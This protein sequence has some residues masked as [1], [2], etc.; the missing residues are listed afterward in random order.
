MAY[1]TIN[2][3]THICATCDNYICNRKPTNGGFI[4]VEGE[5]GKC[6]LV[7]RVDGIPKVWGVSCS[8]WTPWGPVKGWVTKK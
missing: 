1:K 8:A 5:M 4:Q 2:V 3:N 7:N 6:Y